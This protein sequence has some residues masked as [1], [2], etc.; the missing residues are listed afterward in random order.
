MSRTIAQL[1]R[2]YITYDLRLRS[3]MMRI[4]S[5]MAIALVITGATSYF[6]FESGLITKFYNE[7]GVTGLGWFVTFA[8]IVIVLFIV[9][10]ISTMD[11]TNCVLA[12]GLYAVVMGLSLSHIFMTYA[13][14][15]ITR[16]F[17]IAAC[18]FF[19]MSIYGYTTKKD[20][21]SV[22]S[23]M[24]M[25]LIGVIIASLINIFFNSPA[26]YFIVSI[27]TVFIFVG[28]TA[29]DVHKLKSNFDHIGYKTQEK[30]SLMGALILYMDFI[31]LFLALFH[32][33]E[34]ETKFKE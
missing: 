12:L 18:L 27:V 7:Q 32:V 2:G 25:G 34:K 20:L 17:F 1:S 8:P 3:Y 33:S 13:T 16:V 15:E 6:T 30:A 22:G 11:L 19:T 4:F 31:N 21:T 10:Q 24:I 28:L 26:I 23:F 5:Y 14:I 9:P 29:Y